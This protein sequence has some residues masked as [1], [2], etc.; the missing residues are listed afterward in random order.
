MDIRHHSYIS[1][2]CFVFQCEYLIV[3][4]ME[5]G[6]PVLFINVSHARGKSITSRMQMSCLYLE[7][8]S[9]ITQW[10]LLNQSWHSVTD[11]HRRGHFFVFNIYRNVAS[12]T[13]AHVWWGQ[14]TGQLETFPH[15]D[16]SNFHQFVWKSGHVTILTLNLTSVLFHIFIFSYFHVITAINE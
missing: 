15:K 14:A 10:D 16:N 2:F 12:I 11:E 7:T 13:A 1:V 9:G 5:D 3:I 6:H 8:I 4:K